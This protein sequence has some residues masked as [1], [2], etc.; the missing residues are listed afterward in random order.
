MSQPRSPATV[1]NR[2][3]VCANAC[4][5]KG[6]HQPTECRVCRRPEHLLSVA[7]DNRQPQ[8]KGNQPWTAM[9]TRRSTSSPS[10]RPPSCCAFPSRPVTLACHWCYAPIEVKPLGRLPRWCSA[11][12]RHLAWEQARAAASALRGAVRGAGGP[13]RTRGRGRDPAPGAG[14][15]TDPAYPGASDGQRPGLRPRPARTH[16]R[17]PRLRRCAAAPQPPRR[18]P[19]LAERSPSSDS[20]AGRSESTPSAVPNQ[21]GVRM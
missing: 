10:R 6:R 18:P 5:G 12:C 19:P 2:S 17:L 21:R 11:Q 7:A 16:R 14:V 15:G 8:P 3:R 1:T 9:R 4:G 13:R 20:G